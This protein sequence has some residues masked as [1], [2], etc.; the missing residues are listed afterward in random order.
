MKFI[1]AALLI[2]PAIAHAQSLEQCSYDTEYDGKII[3]TVEPPTDT[4]GSNAKRFEDIKHHEEAGDEGWKGYRTFNVTCAPL[5][6][7]NREWT[8][9]VQTENGQV[10]L[11]H[12]LTEYECYRGLYAADDRR[13]VSYGPISIQGSD[14]K[15]GQCFK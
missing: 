4:D 15:R 1:L 13:N 8:L 5:D 6:K 9:F 2:L 12:G 7:V 14:Y 3:H 11:V 10:S